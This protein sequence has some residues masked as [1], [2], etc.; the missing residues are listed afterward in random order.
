MKDFNLE[1]ALA[2]EPV[3]TRDGQKVTEIVHL[4]TAQR[5]LQKIIGVIDGQVNMFCERGY[6]DIGPPFQNELDLFMAPVK[7]IIWLNIFMNGYGVI[8]SCS[9]PYETK[10][11]AEQGYVSNKTE[12][13]LGAY[14][15]EVEI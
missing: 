1:K 11:H 8:F 4:K 3:I 7:R 15:I 13:Y 14:S 2:G 9:R 12:T 5:E 6:F 10:E